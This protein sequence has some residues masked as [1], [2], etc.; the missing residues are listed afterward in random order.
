VNDARYFRPSEHV[1]LKVI[2]IA[3][4]MK[5]S[6]DDETKRRLAAE[7]WDA[8]RTECPDADQ[9]AGWKI[10]CTQ[11]TA[12]V[13]NDPEYDIRCDHVPDPFV[14]EDPGVERMT[15]PDG[16]CARVPAG[17]GR[18]LL[19][20]GDLCRRHR[21]MVVSRGDVFVGTME[22]ALHGIREST[23]SFYAGDEVA[24]SGHME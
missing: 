10:H 14:P 3:S 24:G 7:L 20:Y 12:V 23:F 21:L 5:V 1:E 15:S 8:V 19:D 9:K 13:T 11:A 6:Y 22:P 17:V 16:R 2:G 4:A 18:F